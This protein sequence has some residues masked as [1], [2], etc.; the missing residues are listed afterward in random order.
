MMSE[1]HHKGLSTL[2]RGRALAETETSN[3][4]ATREAEGQKQEVTGC[5]SEGDGPGINGH[6]VPGPPHLYWPISSSASSSWLAKRA[7]LTPTAP[8][9]SMRGPSTLVRDWAQA[10]AWRVSPASSMRPA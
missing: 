9:P 1:A 6:A 7:R 3:A 10:Q 5:F 8:Q 2:V 4:G